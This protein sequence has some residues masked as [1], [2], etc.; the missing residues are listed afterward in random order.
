MSKITSLTEVFGRA[1]EQPLTPGQH[2]QVRV[3]GIDPADVP[4]RRTLELLTPW[5]FADPSSPIQ[6][7][8]ILWLKHRG[9]DIREVEDWS[10]AT[11]DDGRKA[12]TRILLDADDDEVFCTET[13]RRFQQRNL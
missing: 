6:L 10:H 2:V 4:D 8:Q 3:A 9:F 1:D 7:Q 5:V 12:I 11:F 13:K